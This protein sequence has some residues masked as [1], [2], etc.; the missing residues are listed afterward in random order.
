MARTARDGAA[1]K[2]AWAK[3]IESYNVFAVTRSEELLQPE[4]DVRQ[5]LH[6]QIAAFPFLEAGRELA[7]LLEAIEQPLDHIVLAVAGL[8][9]PDPAL[10]V[11][12]GDLHTDAST[13]QVPPHFLLLMRV[14]IQD[15]FCI[16]L[17]K[18]IHSLCRVAR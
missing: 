4:H 5:G 15:S 11:L 18:P 6:R 9:E 2:T 3:R 17:M 7:D 13:A 10:P 8:I 16:C 12:A 1:R 14:P